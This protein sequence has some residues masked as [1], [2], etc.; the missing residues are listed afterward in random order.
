V[1][2]VTNGRKSSLEGTVLAQSRDY[3]A[4]SNVGVE[5]DSNG[6]GGISPDDSTVPDT[7]LI[8]VRD[9]PNNRSGRGNKGVVGLERGLTQKG[10]IWSVS[11]KDLHHNNNNNNKE[12]K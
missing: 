6:V 10:H 5:T 12:F 4:F 9:F 7:G 3:R 2:N 8:P 1:A 11:G